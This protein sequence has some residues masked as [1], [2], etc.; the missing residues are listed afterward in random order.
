[1]RGGH[2]G[3]DRVDHSVV[4]GV[5][6]SAVMGFPNPY[7]QVF[8]ERCGQESRSVMRSDTISVRSMNPLS[9]TSV[10]SEHETVGG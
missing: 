2:Y 4:V 1:M 9:K 3:F 7:K 8:I 10:H 6:P 5:N